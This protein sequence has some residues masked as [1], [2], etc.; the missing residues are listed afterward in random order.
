M[1]IQRSCLMCYLKFLLQAASCI[2][3]SSDF[4]GNLSITGTHFVDNGLTI[5]STSSLE[6][7]VVYINCGNNGTSLVCNISVEDSIFDSNQGG[8]AIFASS[9]L[10][11]GTLLV[12]RCNFT[13]NS[14]L[15]SGA[16][17]YVVDMSIVHVFSSMFLHNNAWTRHGGA[18]LVVYRYSSSDDLI[19]IASDV[20]IQVCMWIF[21]DV[22]TQCYM[23]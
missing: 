20:L 13:N 2:D 4:V 6:K 5:N 17:L 19:P 14:G 16:A 15:T 9:S 1:Q 21:C 7:P 23:F 22:C 12:T 18:I 11:S 3:A 10:G 8:G